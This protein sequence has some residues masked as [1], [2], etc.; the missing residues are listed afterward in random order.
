MKVSWARNVAVQLS[1]AQSCLR[2]LNVLRF[3]EV[4]HEITSHH[5]ARLRFPPDYVEKLRG[6]NDGRI[7]AVATEL[8]ELPSGLQRWSRSYCNTK[9]WGLI[10]HGDFYFHGLE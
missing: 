2:E 3:R 8:L 5:V 10:K 7:T 6:L 9:I 4:P 1:E